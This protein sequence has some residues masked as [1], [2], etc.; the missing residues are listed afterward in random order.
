MSLLD[1]LGKITGFGTLPGL[2]GGVYDWMGGNPADQARPYVEQI[3]GRTSPYLDPFVGR[4]NR[5]GNLLENQYESLMWNPDQKQNAFG[6]GYQ[7]SPGY[8][9]ALDQALQGAG[10]A[11]SAGGMAGSPQHEQMNMDL[12]SNLASRDYNNW[13]GHTLDLY[14][15]GL[16]GTEMLY[17]KGMG[18]SQSMA[19]FISQALS[20]QGGLEYAGGANRNQFISQLLGQL[21]SAGGMAARGGLGGG[22][23]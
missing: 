14:G 20:E 10:H 11:Q 9:F 17:G 18:A 1:V 16:G 13:M 7:Q 22:I 5:A 15:R 19:D 21:M 3:P 8:R 2:A 6:A 12:A 23:G 4:G